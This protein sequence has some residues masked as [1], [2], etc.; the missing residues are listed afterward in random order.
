MFILGGRVLIFNVV[1]ESDGSAIDGDT[2]DGMREVLCGHE[3]CLVNYLVV[4]DAQ[5]FDAIDLFDNPALDLLNC[6]ASGELAA[7]EQYV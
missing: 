6:L 1:D 2:T 5:S 4:F 3:G 7:L